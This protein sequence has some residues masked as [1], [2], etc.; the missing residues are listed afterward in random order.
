MTPTYPNRARFIPLQHPILVRSGRQKVVSVPPRSPPIGSNSDDLL[1]QQKQAMG[2][3]HGGDRRSSGNALPFA[4][5]VAENCAFE[6]RMARNYMRTYRRRCS[7]SSLG[8]SG[9]PVRRMFGRPLHDRTVAVLSDGL[10]L[11]P[12]SNRWGGARRTCLFARVTRDIEQGAGARW[13]CQR[14]RRVGQ[15][16]DRHLGVEQGA[17]G[18]PIRYRCDRG[19]SGRRRGGWHIEQGTGAGQSKIPRTPK[20]RRRLYLGVVNRGYPCDSG[21]SHRRQQVVEVMPLL[22]NLGTQRHALG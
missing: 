9:A 10:A 17:G 2:A 1:I 14:T 3:T 22:P 7:P 12:N 21:A 8:I 15:H 4:A 5:W 18:R 16:G 13:T 6:E 20:S 11:S 19:A